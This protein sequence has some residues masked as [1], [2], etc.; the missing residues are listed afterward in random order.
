MDT[1]TRFEK[2]KVLSFIFRNRYLK[3]RVKKTIIPVVCL[4]S[5]LAATLNVWVRVLLVATFFFPF[6]RSAVFANYR[7]NIQVYQHV[8]KK[9]P[10]AK[11]FAFRIEMYVPS[12]QRT[13]KI[14]WS[15]TCNLGPSSSRA[16]VPHYN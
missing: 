16:T 6:T 10:F 13:W 15:V 3:N 2:A 14:C 1:R 12:I 5:A 7:Q 8:M 11:P 4:L 9:V